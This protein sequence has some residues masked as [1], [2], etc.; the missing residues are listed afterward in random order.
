ML[1]EE[2]VY[3]IPE[4]NGERLKDARLVASPGCMAITSI[5]AMVPLLKDRSLG[6]DKE[7]VVV[8][9]KIGSSGAGGK[10]SAS[11]HFSER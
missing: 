2:F 1:L 11:T 8:D 7:K 4:I 3:A 10:P 6:V 5:L 9:A